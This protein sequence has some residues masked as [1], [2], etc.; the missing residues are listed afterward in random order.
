M[1]IYLTILGW[2]QMSSDF[3]SPL[4]DENSRQKNQD[5]LPK[6][7]PNPTTFTVHQQEQLSPLQWLK[8]NQSWILKIFVQ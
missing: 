3:K 4:S 5:M 7:S 1:N 8:G 2:F 6:V